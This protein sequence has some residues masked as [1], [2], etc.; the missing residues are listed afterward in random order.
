MH[1]I[2]THGHGRIVAA[3]GP[4][5]DNEFSINGNAVMFEEGQDPEGRRRR[6]ATRADARQPPNAYVIEVGGRPSTSGKL[7]TDGL[8]PRV[9]QRGRAAEPGRSSIIGGMTITR[10]FS[11]DPRRARARAG[12]IPPDQTFTPLPPH[13]VA[14][15]LPQPGAVAARRADAFGREAGCA[16]D[17]LRRQSPGPANPQPPLPVQR[18]RQPGRAA[19]DHPSA[20]R[21]A[22]HGREHHRDHR[23]PGGVV[24]AREDRRSSTHALNNNQ[25]RLSP[26]VPPRQDDQRLRWSMSRTTRGW[27]LPGP[28]M[29]F[30]LD[31]AGTPVGGAEHTHRVDDGAPA[32]PGARAEHAR[33][34]RGAGRPS[35]HGGRTRDVDVRSDEPPAG[36]GH[37]SGATGVISGSPSSAG[38]YLVGASV[39]DGAPTIGTEFGWTVGGGGP[40]PPPPPPTG[41]TARAT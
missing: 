29:L 38:T 25:R 35:G 15:Q 11:D 36:R 23:P 2:D 41:G 24:R 26:D 18:R 31:A 12:G 4:R 9:R 1:W 7:A 20:P 6:R 37:Q 28:Y 10:H 5:G 17:W 21:F 40:P 16:R 13:V 19:R 39:A 14:P 34:R 30:A 32:L 33:R 22:N 27:A 8:T 3:I